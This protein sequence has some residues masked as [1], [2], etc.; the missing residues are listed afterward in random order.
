MAIENGTYFVRF[1]TPIGEG[2]GVFTLQD[3]KL[4]GGDGSMIYVGSYS[5]PTPGTINADV[6]VTTHTKRLGET[7]VFGAS[8]VDINLTGSIAGGSGT[9][10]GS[11]PQA[12][13][14]PF[15]ASIERY[16]D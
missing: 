9:V 15:T 7:T 2:G 13:G 4:R 3:G 10:K 11:S 12:P 1:K 5:E 14:V 16:C 6:K 8:E